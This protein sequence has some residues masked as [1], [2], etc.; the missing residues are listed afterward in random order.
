VFAPPFFKGKTNRP[1]T[2]GEIFGI[3]SGWHRW[4]VVMSR[5]QDRRS[6]GTVAPAG[7]TQCLWSFRKLMAGAKPVA[8]LDL[9]SMP[10]KLTARIK[11]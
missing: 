11:P 7:D 10:L 5:E 2:T 3:S 4:C 1:Y 6:Q 8:V 9:K